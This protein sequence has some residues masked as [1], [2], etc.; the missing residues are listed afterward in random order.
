VAV[1]KWIGLVVFLTVADGIGVQRKYI[2]IISEVAVDPN[3]VGIVAYQNKIKELLFGRQR[4][5]IFP[6]FHLNADNGKVMHSAPMICFEYVF[7]ISIE[8]Y[9][10]VNYNSNLN[11]PQ[12]V[13]FEASELFLNR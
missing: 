10:H 4:K 8:F 9:T 3:D 11:S 6:K 13:C 5:K 1:E 7:P 12:G 2:D